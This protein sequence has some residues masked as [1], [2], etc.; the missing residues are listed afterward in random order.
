MIKIAIVENEE[1]DRIALCQELKSYG[2][3]EKLQFDIVE[4]SDGEDIAIDYKGN[5]DI[6]FLDIEMDFMD[7][8]TAAEKIRQLDSEVPIIFVTNSPHYAI[9]GY[10]VNAFDYILK[11]IAEFSFRETLNKVMAKLQKNEDKFISVRTANGNTKM[12]E[13]RIC[14]VEVQDR[15]LFFHTLDGVI[16]TRESLKNMV[17]QLDPE[18]F[19][20]CNRCYLVN[21]S[22]VDSFKNDE[23][24]VNG[25]VVH[26]SR[27]KSK[28][29]LD[30]LNK[31]LNSR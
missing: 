4:F 22:F 23:I 30:A 6:I 8:L 7:G 16:E 18:L 25:D 11:P 9:R 10:K 29:F 3:A 1:K 2:A 13:N 19:V 31:Y 21:L 15:Y 12:A 5:Y 26:M 14:Y 20:L 24:I 17:E 28:S 27:G